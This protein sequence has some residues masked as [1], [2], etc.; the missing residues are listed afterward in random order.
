MLSKRKAFTLIELLV[1]VIII[2]ILA[3]VALPQYQKAVM[4]SRAVQ[5]LLFMRNAGQVMDRWVLEN[6]TPNETVVFLGTQ[7][8]AQLDIDLTGGMTCTASKCS[9]GMFKYWVSWENSYWSV[10]VSYK[11]DEIYNPAVGQTSGAE[12]YLEKDV[13]TGGVS[14]SCSSY[15]DDGAK[16]CAALCSL[17]SGFC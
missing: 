17:D 1:V 15:D 9:D 10:S 8:D 3:A 16:F 2:G 4:K 14:K 13:D 6:G 5:A 7:P 11:E 12:A